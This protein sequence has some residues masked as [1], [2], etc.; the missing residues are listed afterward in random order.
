MFTK[1]FALFLLTT[2]AYAQLDVSADINATAVVNATLTEPGV[3]ILLPNV[4]ASAQPEVPVSTFVQIGETVTLTEQHQ[5]EFTAT[6]FLEAPRTEVAESV[7]IG[8]DLRATVAVDIFNTS[9]GSTETF[10]IPNPT[11]TVFETVTN[12]EIAHETEIVQVNQ[13]LTQYIPPQTVTQTNIQEVVETRTA[14]EMVPGATV[15]QVAEENV[16]LT[17]TITQTQTQIIPITIVQTPGG[18]VRVVGNEV[19]PT[20]V[21]DETLAAEANATVVIL[22]E[23]SASATPI[24][25]Q[26][27][28]PAVTQQAVVVPQPAAGDDDDDAAGTNALSLLVALAG[29]TFLLA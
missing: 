11:E 6:L 17:E 28:P 22:G 19:N 4:S 10:Y 23:G 16:V 13:T 18:V 14:I 29:L 26:A 21:V 20:V 12:T 8:A 27:P 25:T 7:V 24:I 1:C 5:P 3:L 2:V 15:T 9:I